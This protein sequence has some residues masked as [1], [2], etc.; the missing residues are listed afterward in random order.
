MSEI[1]SYE[2][3]VKHKNDENCDIKG[4]AR[5]GCYKG[6]D[7][8]EELNKNEKLR[9]IT[10]SEAFEDCLV[11]IKTHIIELEEEIKRQEKA[12]VILDDENSELQ[13]RIDK[14]I[15]YVEEQTYYSM[16]TYTSSLYLEKDNLYKLLEILKGEK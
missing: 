4:F 9:E 11:F 16:S 12:N 2:E 1:S 7:F 14:A 8:Y 3:Y 13:Q 5:Y 6:L 15:K 10:N